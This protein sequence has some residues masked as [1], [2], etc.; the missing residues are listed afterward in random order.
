MFNSW[1]FKIIIPI[2]TLGLG[3]Y[4][5]HTGT[6]V[7][8]YPYYKTVGHVKQADA[9]TLLKEDTK[10][11]IAYYITDESKLDFEFPNVN[12]TVTFI[13]GTTGAITEIS[14]NG[15]TVE[16]EPNSI[17]PGMSGSPVY[18]SNDELLGY[19]S[20]SF[21]SSSIYCIWR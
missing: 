20:G 9:W 6:Q 7:Y 14:P 11:D 10:E 3:Y 18:N 15:F 5:G 4:I 8:Y 12:D 19:V 17:L 21:S 16:V 1:F 13:T 2:L